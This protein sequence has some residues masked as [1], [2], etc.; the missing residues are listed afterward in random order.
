[1]KD[2]DELIL[3]ELVKNA[4]A[5]N[6]AIAKKLRV[7]EG[8]VRNKINRFIESGVIKSF[9]VE[10]ST[11]KGFKAFSMVE[12]EKNTDRKLLVPKLKAID[13]VVRVFDMAG[14]IDFMVEIHTS[15]PEEF[16]RAIE[17]IRAIPKVSD[18]ESMVVLS[19]N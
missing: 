13:G 15:S 10:L 12:V 9:T 14:R 5:S 6:I 7:S 16:N 4:R 1:M 8:T 11:R 2:L 17:E 19:T 3:K 18:T